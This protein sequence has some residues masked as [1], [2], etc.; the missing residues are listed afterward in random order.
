[1]SDSGFWYLAKISSSPSR[2]SSE[3]VNPVV[4]SIRWMRFLRRF[5]MRA[6]VIGWLMTA[7][8]SVNRSHFYEKTFFLS[9]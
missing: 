8:N 1:M 4:L 6:A 9:G 3:A 7:T 5:G 2:M